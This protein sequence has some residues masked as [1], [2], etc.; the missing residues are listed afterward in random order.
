MN[1][2]L[3]KFNIKLLKAYEV[4]RV[5]EN[6]SKSHTQKDLNPEYSKSKNKKINESTEG[7]KR[8]T[9]IFADENKR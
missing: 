7:Q 9:D 8:G 2:K 1:L 6:I 5:E 4:S 3:M